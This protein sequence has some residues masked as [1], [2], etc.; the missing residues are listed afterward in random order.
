VNLLKVAIM[1]ADD[2]KY[3]E[4]EYPGHPSDPE[5]LPSST[6]WPIVLA[7]GLLL[8]LWGIITSLIVLAAGVLCMG[9]ALTGW[10]IELNYE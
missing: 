1:E 7:F 3:D 5:K 10:I 6:Y 2:L 8:F 9:V 4:R